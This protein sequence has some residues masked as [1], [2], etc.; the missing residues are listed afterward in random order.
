MVETV[1]FEVTKITMQPSKKFAF[2]VGITFNFT[3]GD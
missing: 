3:I 1:I 2:D